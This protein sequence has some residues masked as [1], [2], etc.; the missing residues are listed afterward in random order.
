L[1]V[2]PTCLYSS[3]LQISLWF[4]SV[5]VLI[6]VIIFPSNTL[7]FIILFIF[8]N[9]SLMICYWQSGSGLSWKPSI[10]MSSV[11]LLSL[12]VVTILVADFSRVLCIRRPRRYLK[13][14]FLPNGSLYLDNNRLKY[15]SFGLV[16]KKKIC[17]VSNCTSIPYLYA[18]PVINDCAT[19]TCS[20]FLCV[21]ESI[22]VFSPAWNSL[23]LLSSPPNKLSFIRC[24]LRAF[25]CF[26]LSV[27]KM[28]VVYSLNELQELGLELVD[29]HN[30]MRVF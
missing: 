11:T 7:F 26:S 25:D 15:S 12:L 23:N 16:P 22:D 1:I 4:P 29:V 24:S 21:T 13:F 2:F 30:Y 19:I 18:L 10:K 14:I 3:L 8:P 6:K 17:W 5:Y 28:S 20:F 9:F 27:L